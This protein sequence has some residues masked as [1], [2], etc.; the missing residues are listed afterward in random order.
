MDTMNE[1]IVHTHQL[2]HD[3]KRDIA[4]K[5]GLRPVGQTHDT[6]IKVHDVELK[7]R[8]DDSDE[9][10]DE[11]EESGENK[12]ATDKEK[13][14]DLRER[15]LKYLDKA[16]RVKR[17]KHIIKKIKKHIPFINNEDVDN[18][19]NEE[20][21]HAN[22]K[23]TVYGRGKDITN[24]M[25]HRAIDK[26]EINES[27]I[28][29]KNVISFKEATNT[30]SLAYVPI[31]LLY[32][33]QNDNTD[34]FNFYMFFKPDSNIAYRITVMDDTAIMSQETN[35]V[36]DIIDKYKD[37][38][39]IE[40]VG[41]IVAISDI[42]FYK[43][44]HRVSVYTYKNNGASEFYFNQTSGD[45]CTLS[46][47][48]IAGLLGMKEIP[49]NAEIIDTFNMSEL[50]SQGIMVANMSKVI[51]SID[52]KDIPCSYKLYNYLTFADDNVTINDVIERLKHSSDD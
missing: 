52:V 13:A 28:R 2:D 20:Y 31:Y 3:S 36:S 25:T 48:I 33:M 30:K 29:S 19:D 45:F 12:E 26:T 35:T 10:E 50:K 49:S 24:I 7:P 4:E 47:D 8:K 40:I 23:D 46:R 27:A 37:D 38:E 22:E 15:R 51:N 39:D 43:L 11:E 14:D 44:N 17:R 32:V 42:N 21:D 6:N 5:Y 41:V 34:K 18:S 9:T 16:N 1:D